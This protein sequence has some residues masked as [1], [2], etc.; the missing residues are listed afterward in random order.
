ME[1]AEEEFFSRN[2]M[3]NFSFSVLRFFKKKE[4]ERYTHIIAREIK[5]RKR[6][7]ARRENGLK[8]RVQAEKK[9][10]EGKR[11]S[12]ARRDSEVVKRV[13]RGANN[14]LRVNTG[15]IGRPMSNNV[16]DVRV[17]LSRCYP[18]RMMFIRWYQETGRIGMDYEDAHPPP[19]GSKSI[20][21]INGSGYTGITWNYMARIIIVAITF[22]THSSW[23]HRI[24]LTGIN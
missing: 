8:F 19:G 24:A 1:K 6:D 12:T 7:R 20:C 3:N 23:C 15:L 4:K 16:V 11:G 17:M 13:G 21:P 10:K 22:N 5:T 9:K 18:R 14:I 2:L